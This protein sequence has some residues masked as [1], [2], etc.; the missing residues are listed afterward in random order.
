MDEACRIRA[1]STADLGAVAAIEEAAF[2]DPWSVAAFRAH[3]HHLFL[4]AEL[5][6]RVI[7][8]LVAWTAPPEAEI[9]NVAVDRGVRR[10]GAGRALLGEALHQLG[11]SGVSTVFLEVRPS[12]AA[13]RALYQSA[14]FREIAVRRGYYQE[15]REDALVLRRDGAPPA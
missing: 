3:L 8:Y 10:R 11:S 4:V 9:L 2:P 7:G 13:A 15:P 12:N 5:D 6:R 1:A 14:G